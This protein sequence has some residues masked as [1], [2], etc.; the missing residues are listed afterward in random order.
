VVSVPIQFTGGNGAILDAQLPIRSAYSCAQIQDAGRTLAA[1]RALAIVGRKYVAQGGFSL[2][3][4]DSNADNKIDILDFGMLV[5]DLG[6]GKTPTSRSNFDRDNR[7]GNG[8]F[9]FVGINFLRIGERCSAGF[10][11]EQPITRISVKELR[12][13]G[14][15]EIAAGDL[16]GD[17]WVDT[18]DVAIAMQGG[19]A[20]PEASK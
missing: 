14:M 3:G 18:T 15:G 20:R 7:V 9:S 1:V 8:D 19:I 6:F 2:I 5:T 13:R 10:D 11:G 17:G 16:N 4:G 12:R